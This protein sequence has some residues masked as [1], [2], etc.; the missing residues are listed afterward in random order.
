MI[1][2]TSRAP[3]KLFLTKKT[4][5]KCFMNRDK[6][7]SGTLEHSLGARGGMTAEGELRPLDGAE[8]ETLTKT[9]SAFA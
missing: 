5:K 3:P 4:E 2:P 1:L 8:E 7:A 9:T 6:F